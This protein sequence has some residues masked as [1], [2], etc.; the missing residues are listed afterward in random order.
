MRAEAP[1]V[2]FA[3]GPLLFLKKVRVFR[4]ACASFPKADILVIMIGFLSLSG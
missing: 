4:G 2:E 1:L 3:D